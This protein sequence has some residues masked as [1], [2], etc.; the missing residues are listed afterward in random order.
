[1]VFGAKLT[2]FSL[3]FLNDEEKFRWTARQASLTVFG[4]CADTVFALPTIFQIRNLVVR[5]QLTTSVGV[6]E[7]LREF[8]RFADIRFWIQISNAQAIPVLLQGKVAL[9][10]NALRIARALVAK[11]FAARL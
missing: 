11:L 3:C 5:A 1:M 9:A 7:V 4:D 2:A 10:T 8:T 6:R